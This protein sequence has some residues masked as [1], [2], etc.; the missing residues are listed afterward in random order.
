MNL[1]LV[2]SI[3]FGF[4]GALIAGLVNRKYIDEQAEG[5]HIDKK[6]DIFSYMTTSQ[7]VKYIVALIFAIVPT[8]LIIALGFIVLI[9]NM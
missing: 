9:E 2:L 4:I 6:K 7:K 1:L 8:T 5:G 3:F